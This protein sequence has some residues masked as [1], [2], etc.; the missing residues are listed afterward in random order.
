MELIQK[1][2]KN[3]NLQ[4]YFFNSLLK[5]YQEFAHWFARKAEDNAYVFEDDRGNINGFLYLKIENEVITDVM[6]HLPAKRRIKVGTMKINARG[7]KMGE[8][9]L[10]K[11]F[12][13]ASHNGVDEIYVT[14]FPHH[15]VLIGLF[16]KYGFS[17]VA[18]KISENG[19]ELVLLKE[20]HKLQDDL[21][22]S[23]P[24]VNN[25]NVK[26]HLLSLKPEWHT[27][28]LPDSIL[29]NENARIIEDVSHTN[30]IHKVYLSAMQGLENLKRGDILL[31]YRTSDGLGP[32]HYRSVATSI[33]VIEEYRSIHSFATRDEFMTYCRPYSVFSDAEL[34]QFWARKKYPHVFRFT[35]NTALKR[36]VTRGEMIEQ[37]GLDPNNYW[38]FMALTQNQFD[39]IVRAGQIDEGIII[40]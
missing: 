39:S 1:K 9:F 20:L 19:V 13:H 5:D 34:N 38:G 29:K 31:I 6:P 4:D 12:D 7:T 18:E 3:I 17:R 23:Y 33:G 21:V 8:R 16:Q 28:L 10:K 37:F 22:K 25:M 2:F 24:M 26:R 35:Y 32:A 36:R 27:R 15:D 40:N 30:S 14:V 11:I